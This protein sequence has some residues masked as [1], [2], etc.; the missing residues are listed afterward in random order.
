M[1]HQLPILLLLLLLRM[2]VLLLLSTGRHLLLLLLLLSTGRQAR[3]A[4]C[5]ALNTCRSC[6]WEGCWAIPVTQY[7][8]Y[9]ITEHGQVRQGRCVRE[10]WLH[11]CMRA[12]MR[13]CVHVCV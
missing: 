8:S 10:A 2:V 1:L 13:A 4:A 6:S 9:G 5:T 11:A 12:C 7:P 3:D